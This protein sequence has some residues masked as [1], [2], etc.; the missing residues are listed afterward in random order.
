MFGKRLRTLYKSISVMGNRVFVVGAIEAALVI[1]SLFA[2][3]LLCSDFRLPERALFLS[4]TAVLLGIRLPLLYW[5]NLM[6]GWWRYTGINESLDIGKAVF[7]GS[8]LF[9][10]LVQFIFIPKEMQ[11]S[12]FPIA[13]LVVESIVTICILAAGRLLSRLLADNT[14]HGTASSKLVVIIGAGAA[15]Q[16]M[17]RDINKP[18]SGF[19]ALACLDD[20]PSKIGIRIGGIEVVGP[21]DYLPELTQK[22]H[23]DEVWIVVPSATNDQMNRFVSICSSTGVRY[24]T[25]PSWREIM[26][27]QDVLPQIREVNLEDLLGRDP[28][29]INLN[30]VQREIR[31]RVVMVTGAAGSIGTELCSQL[32][33]YDPAMLVCVDRNENGMFFLEH[34]HRQKKNAIKMAYCVADISNGVR[35]AGLFKEHGVQV[36]FHAAAY[37]HVPVMESNISEALTNNVFALI[38]LLSIAEDS[39]CETFVMISSDKA[40]NPT[41]VMGATKR[42]GELILSSRPESNMR[43]V[44][45]RFGNVLG[46]NGSIVP[47]LQAQIRQNLEL[48]I[49]HPEIKRFFMTIQEAVSL[50]LQAC[51]IGEHGD[52]LVLDMGEPMAILDLARSL[53]RL[54]G[55]SE[56]DVPIRIIGLRD[57]EKLKE[58]MFYQSEEVLPTSC[59]KIKRTRSKMY[60]WQKLRR[61]LEELELANT[62]ESAQSIKLKMKEIVFEYNFATSS[63]EG[64]ESHGVL[65]LKSNQSRF[66]SVTSH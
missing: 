55:K 19:A 39:G 12:H 60:S 46:S 53:I 49:T 37:K 43:C 57:G 14:V 31:G 38:E 64:H 6:Q 35:M 44:S 61:L 27:G 56:Q 17:L 66:P 1:F 54:S 8:I 30:I 26:S 42:I 2:A 24:R 51:A 4:S 7:S 34:A 29:R 22:L 23:I 11:N 41:N 25:L 59:E 18:G 15:A 40:V 63:I 32:L 36:I 48:T 13:V 21:V 65:D 28:V 20:D 58:E 33:Q 50:V 10:L 5:F 9:F 16:L 3:F 45:V 52:L 47:I 62:T